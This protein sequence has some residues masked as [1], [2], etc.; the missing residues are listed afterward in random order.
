MRRLNACPHDSLIRRR[1]RWV[2]RLLPTAMDGTTPRFP[3][4][5]SIDPTQALLDRTPWRE[6]AVSMAAL[7]LPGLQSIAS[8]QALLGRTLSRG[9]AMDA[10]ASGF[11]VSDPFKG[12]RPAPFQPGAT[13]RET[14]RPNGQ[15]LKA[16]PMP[17]PRADPSRPARPRRSFPRVSP[18]RTVRRIPFCIS[19]RTPGTLRFLF[20]RSIQGPTARPIPARGKAPGTRA[21]NGQGLKARPIPLP[22]A[23][24]S[25][26]A[27]TSVPGVPF[28][29]LRFVFRVERAAFFLERSGP[30]VFFLIVD[31]PAQRAEVGGTDGEHGVTAL[32]RESG[33][34][35]RPG[36]EPF[37]RGGF[38][39]FHQ[40]NSGDSSQTI[41]TVSGKPICHSNIS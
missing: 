19:R 40:Q 9:H 7:V 26:P 36:L 1:S 5:T 33:Q 23:H 8:V 32:P 3:R 20:L 29:V 15:G 18:R 38:E 30:V 31:V 22:R 6:L 14:V 11:R 17:L 27:R 34:R 35:G 13:P 4:F 16:R 37:R 12:Q 39:F 28:I 25:P 2:A 21:P 10:T 41:S 24:L